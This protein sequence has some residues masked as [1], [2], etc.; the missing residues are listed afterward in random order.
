MPTPRRGGLAAVEHERPGR[1][2]AVDAGGTVVHFRHPADVPADRLVRA[3]TDWRPFFGVISVNRD[4]LAG[5]AFPAWKAEHV[6]RAYRWHYGLCATPADDARLTAM[7]DHPQYRD[8]VEYDLLGFGLD[9]GVEYRERRWRRLL[10][11]VDR[12]GRSTQFGETLSQDEDVA[13]QIMAEER[14]GRKAAPARRKMSEFGVQE[15]LL[16]LAVDRLAEL[17]QAHAV[18]AGAKPRQVKPVARPETALSRLRKKSDV[19]HVE[20]TLDR[21]FGRKNADGTPVAA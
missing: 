20:F 2:F 3:L 10:N 7:L 9:L 4:D 16:A 15:E 8:A 11:V 12:L 18:S 1:G 6:L 17:V 5:T 14:K 13:K 19:K 21:V